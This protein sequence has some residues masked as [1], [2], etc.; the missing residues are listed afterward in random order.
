MIPLQLNLVAHICIYLS[1]P[2][3]IYPV[4]IK[5]TAIPQICPQM[6]SLLPLKIMLVLWPPLLIIHFSF[7]LAIL[8]IYMLWICMYL[9]EVGFTED[10]AVG[11]T[12]KIC[13]K[14]TRFYWSTCPD[15]HLPIITIYDIPRMHKRARYTPYLLPD[16]ISVASENYF[17]TLTTPSD[18]PYLLPSD[19]PNTLHVM[20]KYLPL[21]GR[22]EI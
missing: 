8:I 11:N 20:K 7:L 12:I 6:P 2:L 3:M 13:Y 18:S 9:S 21:L 22:V 15:L 5:E 14:S 16:A 1:P 10:N 19:D 17:S 4:C